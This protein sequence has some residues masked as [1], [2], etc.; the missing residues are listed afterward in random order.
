MLNIEIN[1]TRLAIE[2]SY[3]TGQTIDIKELVPTF[4]KLK[5]KLQTELSFY[6]HYLQD[7]NV[8]VFRSFPNTTFLREKWLKLI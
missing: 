2:I 1:V 7:E 8:R 4:S 3:K 6:I 5:A